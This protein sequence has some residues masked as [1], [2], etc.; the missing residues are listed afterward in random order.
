MFEYEEFTEIDPAIFLRN[1]IQEEEYL[2]LKKKHA[3]NMILD[4]GC[5][6]GPFW[7]LITGNHIIG[8]DINIDKTTIRRAKKYGVNLVRADAQHIPLKDNTASL[9]FCPEI[10]EHLDNP[11]LTLREASRILKQ[12]GVFLVDVPCIFDKVILPSLTPIVLTTEKMLR[13]MLNI[14]GKKKRQKSKH[15]TTRVKDN[16]PI[17]IAEKIFKAL[18]KCR[19]KYVGILG[20]RILWL[21]IQVRICVTEHKNRYGWSWTSL[22]K[23]AG[24]DIEKI[25]GCSILHPIPILNLNLERWNR[26]EQKIRSKRPFQYLG[27]IIC[28]TAHKR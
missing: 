14:L 25:Q 23:N 7:P 13:T 16:Q 19:L 20:S 28:I 12:P 8:I 24:F 11:F 22:I 15:S 3:I 27:Q 10:L 2:R 6:P 5:G 17:G 9:I 1:K 4:I 18:K 26:Y 21:L